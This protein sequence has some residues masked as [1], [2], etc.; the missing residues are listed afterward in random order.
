MK[1]RSIAI[2]CA[3]A[4]TLS[5]CHESVHFVSE[6]IT[7]CDD[8]PIPGT[9]NPTDPNQ[10]TPTDPNQPTPTDPNQPTPTDPNQPTPTDPNQPTPTDPEQPTPTDPN[11]PTP[12]DPE[13]PTPTDPDTDTI[14]IRIMAG[15]ITSGSNESYDAEASQRILQA[16]K[17]DIA[18]IQ[19][20]KVF[21]T[22]FD[23]FVTN[24][25]GPEFYYFRGTVTENFKGTD[26]DKSAK[27]NGIISRYEI[28]ESGEWRPQYEKTVSGNVTYTNAYDDRQ[29]TWAVIDIPGNRDLLAISVHLHTDNHAKEFNPLATL[30]AEKQKEG[31]Y[32]VVIGGDFNTK[33]GSDGRDAVLD[34]TALMDIF[35][36]QRGEWPVDQKGNPA[37]NKKRAS[38][39]DW[40]MFS[41]DLEPLEVGTEIGAHTGESAYPNGHVFDSRVYDEVGEL[42]MVQPVEAAD[43]GAVN[44]QHMPVIRTFAVPAEDADN[45]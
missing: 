15:N 5:A 9:V 43:S 20:F 35:Y 30:I 18:M 45:P 13:Q 28:I 22:P 42:Y 10:P 41:H 3:L 6:C 16:I 21:K 2:C 17:P 44:M 8:Q 38:P 12:T 32:Y 19:E 34:S 33:E 27:P 23:D 4:L 25:F 36:A 1:Y 11:Q 31:N 29:W 39:L 24:I 14:Q 40:L 37:T 26:T 7:G